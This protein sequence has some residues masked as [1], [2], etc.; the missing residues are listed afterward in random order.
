MFRC[1]YLAITLFLT[2]LNFSLSFQIHVFLLSLS[3]FPIPSPFFPS[4]SCL[5]LSFLP[6][7]QFS[8]PLTVSLQAP[9]AFSL[10]L[11]ATLASLLS[12]SLCLV[13]CCI[14]NSPDRKSK[15]D[16]ENTA[17][18]GIKKHTHT[19]KH[20][21]NS[22]SVCFHTVIKFGCIKEPPPLNLYL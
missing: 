1:T 20:T 10:P 22:S 2:E 16:A 4:F 17:Q 19:Q 8:S 13:L 9:L 7:C 11:S 5:F 12:P 15:V 6:A 21:E 14:T 3:L 18:G